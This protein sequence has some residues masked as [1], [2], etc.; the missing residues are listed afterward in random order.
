MVFVL[1]FR[2]FFKL[3]SKFCWESCGENSGGILNT[4]NLCPAA[5]WQTTRL[6]LRRKKRERSGEN[7][8]EI[9]IKEQDNTCSSLTFLVQMLAFQFLLRLFLLFS[10]ILPNPEISLAI[11]MYNLFI[12]VRENNVSFCFFFW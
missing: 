1:V 12:L 4:R 11:S 10:D 6:A 5:S 2:F 7:R 9:S 8:K 3:A